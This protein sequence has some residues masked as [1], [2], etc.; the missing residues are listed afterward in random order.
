MPVRYVGKCKVQDLVAN[1]DV[2][3]GQNPIRH[4]Y[5]RKQSVQITPAS[6]PRIAATA[7][8]LNSI[9]GD[10]EHRSRAGVRGAD[11]PVQCT[12]VGG[13]SAIRKLRSARSERVHQEN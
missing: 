2:D 13:D 1:E 4:P 3:D 7:L 12:V 8:V 6:A 5:A 9:S 10:Q 11:R